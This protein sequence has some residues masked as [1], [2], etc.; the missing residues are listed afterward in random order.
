[1][2]VDDGNDYNATECPDEERRCISSG[3]PSA[4]CRAWE[5]TMLRQGR[6]H[7]TAPQS[8]HCG[9]SQTDRPRVHHRALSLTT[10]TVKGRGGL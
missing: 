3:I 6:A 9:I 10:T 2:A 7:D 4:E 8:S 1:M 5:R